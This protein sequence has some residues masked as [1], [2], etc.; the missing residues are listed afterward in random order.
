VR[1]EGEVSSTMSSRLRSK[2]RVI[3]RVGWGTEA[4]LWVVVRREERVEI[5]VMEVGA[6]RER[7]GE[8]RERMG[9]WG[10]IEMYV[11]F[12]SLYHPYNHVRTLRPSP[13]G[14]C[15]VESLLLTNSMLEML[16]MPTTSR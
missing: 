9:K 16:V 8:R 14:Y 4:I 3:W 12:L 7:N 10:R 11:V 6:G 5:W 1:S 2:G 13:I 15:G